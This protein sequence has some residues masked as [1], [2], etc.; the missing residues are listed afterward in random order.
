MSMMKTMLIA[1]IAIILLIATKI[2]FCQCRFVTHLVCVIFSEQINQTPPPVFC[3]TFFH[4]TV[5]IF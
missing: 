5:L 1:L 4:K 3:E 2:G